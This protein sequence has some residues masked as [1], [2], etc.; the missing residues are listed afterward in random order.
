MIKFLT[1]ILLLT[2]GLA[3]R[4]DVLLPLQFG[5]KMLSK[6]VSVGPCS[7]SLDFSQA[8]NSQYYSVVTPG[9]P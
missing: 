4:A 7:N 9:I 3:A 5:N 2:L 1:I 6:I 8:C